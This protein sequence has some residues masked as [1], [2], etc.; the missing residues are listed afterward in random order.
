MSHP[1][2]EDEANGGIDDDHLQQPGLPATVT[3]AA[4]PDRHLHLQLRW[5]RHLDH[6]AVRRASVGGTDRTMIRAPRRSPTT[7]YGVPTSITDFDGNIT[8]FVLD[9]TATCWKKSS[10]AASTRNGPTTPPARC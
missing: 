9:S 2:G 10:P 8:T 4:G 6:R 3:D 5:R 7:T 1:T